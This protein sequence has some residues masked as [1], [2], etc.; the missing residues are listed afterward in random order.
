MFPSDISAPPVFIISLDNPLSS[1]NLE[2]LSKATKSFLISI[3]V[4][5]LVYLLF[6]ASL[7]E[8]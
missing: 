1:K 7:N 3:S 4:F 6:E 2:A 5:S 8:P